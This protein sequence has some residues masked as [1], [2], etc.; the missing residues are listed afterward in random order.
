MWVTHF[1]TLGVRSVNSSPELNSRATIAALIC[2][3]VMGPM[4]FLLMPLYV[5]ALVDHL[6]LSTQ[7]VGTL[8]SLE[9]LGSCLA[10]LSALFWIRKIDWRRFASTSALALLALNLVSTAVSDNFEILILVRFAA[11]FGS[12]SLLAI[13]VAALGDTAKLDRNF[14]LAVAGQLGL[15]GALFFVLPQSIAEQGVNAVFAIFAGCAFFAIFASF[16]VPAK[17]RDHTTTRLSGAGNWRPLWGLAG[18]ASFYVAQTAFWAFVERMGV[19]AEFSAEFIGV[20]LGLSTLLSI[21]AALGVGWLALI[22]SRFRIMVIAA[23]GQLVCLALLVDGF[24]AATYLVAVFLFQICWNSWLP[25]Q[26]ANVAAVDTSG[27][28]TVLLGLFQAIGGVTGPILVSRFL[29]GHSF[30]PVNIVAAVF[31]VLTVCLFA[32]IAIRRASPDKIHP[33]ALG[34]S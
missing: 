3:F 4:F 27:R 32:P 10:S 1:T 14:A 21:G 5:G 28:F 34:E 9:L 15:S 16:F 23:L 33:A 29:T 8:T 30:L 2:L 13:A 31:V 11:G 7:Q 17:G 20:A 18:C 24:S 6:G 26:M 25:I 22:I 12:G 19:D